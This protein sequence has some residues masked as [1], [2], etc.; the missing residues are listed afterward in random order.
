MVSTEIKDALALTASICTVLQF[1][2]GVFVCRKIVRNGSTGSSSPLA[3]VTCYT[4]CMLW[5][6]YGM[7]ISDRFIVFVNIFGS[8]LQASYVVVFTVY[9]VKRHRVIKQMI[10][11]TC[12]VMAVYL[13]SFYD[14]DRQQAAKYVGLLCCAVT[15]L[16]FAS[17]LTLMAHV[18]KAKSTES[19]PFPVIVASLIVSCE[20][21]AYGSILNDPFVRI[22][23]FL[24]CVLSAFQLSFFCVY[25]NEKRTDQAHLI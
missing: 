17:P 3:F 16:F 12:F 10:A 2:A 22:P 1:L 5:M 15:V 13:Y 6:R 25:R 7:L 9:A 11:A 23:N 14:T 21:F 8:T 20:W 24:G 18:I 19:L 4:S